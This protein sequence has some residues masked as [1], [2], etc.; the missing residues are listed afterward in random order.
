MP[1]PKG[2]VA[3]FDAAATSSYAHGR[4]FPSGGGGLVSTVDDYARFALMLEGGGEL[5]GARILSPRP[6][7]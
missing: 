7:S 3:L 5:G 1:N 2:G 4:R 6:S